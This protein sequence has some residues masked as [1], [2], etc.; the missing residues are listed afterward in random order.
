MAPD[1][2]LVSRLRRWWSAA[3]DG[4]LVCEIAPDYVAA[5]RCAGR[6]IEAWSV[7]ALPEGAVQPGPLSDNIPN[8]KVIEDVLRKVVAAVGDGHGRCALLVPDLLARVALL[9]FDIL[10]DRPEEVEALVRW[11]LSRDL[12]FDLRQAV[13]SFEKYP[14]RGAAY[15]VI[16]VVAVRGLIRQYE[17]CV[18]RLGLKPGWVTLSTLAAADCL[19][20]R[21]SPCL[22]VKRDGASLG[23]AIVHEGAVRFF[24]SLP[25]PASERIASVEPLF[26]KIYPALV[27]FQDQWGQPV[28][29]GVWAGAAG[30][31]TALAEMLERETG[32]KLATLS[33]TEYHLPWRGTEPPNDRRLLPSLGWARREAE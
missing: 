9:E 13:V 10:P 30:E 1:N 2:G 25:L 5:L 7:E 6:R 16:A 22:L 11:R 26:E 14:A 29:E 19:G 12:P 18:E 23:L 27:Y 17:E 15:E 3:G 32:C 20:S 4:G 33:L 8:Q 21:S 24:R 28:S 31:G